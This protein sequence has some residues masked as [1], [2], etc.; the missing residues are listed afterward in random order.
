M[1]CQGNFLCC[2]KGPRS[3]EV[4]QEKTPDLNVSPC[5][6]IHSALN[7]WESVPLERVQD[8]VHRLEKKKLIIIMSLEKKKLQLEIF[9]KLCDPLKPYHSKNGKEQVTPKS[10]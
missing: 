6:G 10:F 4:C 5:K 1:Y 3:E 7:T 2:D 9:L 8:R